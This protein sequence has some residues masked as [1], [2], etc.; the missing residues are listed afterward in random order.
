MNRTFDLEIKENKVSL[1]TLIEL[2]S[3]PDGKYTIAVSDYKKERSKDQ[4]RKLWDTIN[5]ICM[6]EDGDLRWKEQTYINILKMANIKGFRVNSPMAEIEKIK[7]TPHHYV[8]IIDMKLVHGNMWAKAD[9]Y[10]GSSLMNTDEMSRLIEC[11]ER[12]L[13]ELGG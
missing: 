12:Y 3:L 4:N 9:V 5:A 8:N 1:S 7:N 13:A 2:S 11:A 6:L 10:I